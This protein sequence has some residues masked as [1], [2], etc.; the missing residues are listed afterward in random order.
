MQLTQFNPQYPIWSQ[1]H[2]QKCFLNSEPGINPEYPSVWPQNKIKRHLLHFIFKH[3]YM[4]LPTA[5][6]NTHPTFK[7]F[8]PLPS[9]YTQSLRC[10][11]CPYWI[12]AQMHSFLFYPHAL[13]SPPDHNIYYLIS[14]PTPLLSSIW[15]LPHLPQDCSQMSPPLGTVF[16][17]SPE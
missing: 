13:L 11:V 5:N 16:Y 4:K 1:E 9:D 6:F 3:L 17:P 2:C 10:E 12:L 15:D 14:S 7:R 8:Q